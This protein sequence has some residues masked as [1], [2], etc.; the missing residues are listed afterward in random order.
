MKDRTP[1][2]PFT[3]SPNIVMGQKSNA[4][5]QSVQ[6]IAAQGRKEHCA[7]KQMSGNP[8]APVGLGKDGK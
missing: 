2:M 7:H 4:V 5:N 6:G 8:F 1:Q 3:Y